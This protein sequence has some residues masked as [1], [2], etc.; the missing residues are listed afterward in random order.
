MTGTGT[1]GPTSGVA[2]RR[3]TSDRLYN[4]YHGAVLVYGGFIA[5]ILAHAL[6]T[7]AYDSVAAMIPF[8][9]LFIVLVAGMVWWQSRRAQVSTSRSGRATW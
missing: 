9:C 3:P 6:W 4:L 8:S 7:G 5:G 2:Q 1:Y